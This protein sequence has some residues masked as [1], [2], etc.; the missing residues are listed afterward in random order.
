MNNI[1][2]KKQKQIINILLGIIIGL[3]ISIIGIVIYKH[4]IPKG[5][6]NSIEVPIQHEVVNTNKNNEKENVEFDEEEIKKW[7]EEHSIINGYFILAGND[8]DSTNADTKN[9]SNILGWSLMFGGLIQNSIEEIPLDYTTGFDYQY[10]YPLVFIK[11]ILNTY[12]GIG[13]DYI[14]TSF[15]N[16]S[17]K[18][19]ANFSIENDKFIVKVIA[20]GADIYTSSEI[21]KIYL[22]KENIIAVRYDLK[23]CTEPNGG[24][25]NVGS[26]EILLKKTNNGYN[27]LKAYKVEN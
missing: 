27:L 2:K 6:S 21:N 12:F 23:D 26:R 8:F 10:T 25:E 22:K 15:M 20:T 24:C 11:E 17:F 16:E 5:N 4:I 19:Y 14:D 1:E 7:L 9:Y 18:N 13:L 3:V